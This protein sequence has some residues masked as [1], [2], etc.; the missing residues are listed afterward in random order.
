MANEKELPQIDKY[1]G[2]FLLENHL[3]LAQN[4]VGEIIYENEC[5]KFCFIYNIQYS[6]VFESIYIANKANG[7]KYFVGNL[8]EFFHRTINFNDLLTSYTG[9]IH[10]LKMTDLDAYSRIIPQYLENVFKN[11]DFSWEKEYQEYLKQKHNK[12]YK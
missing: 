8:V 11:C 9:E 5:L 3:T 1:F 4:E 2:K 6:P 7:E 10:S 12:W